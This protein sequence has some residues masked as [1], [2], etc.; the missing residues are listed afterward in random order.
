M[1]AG[2]IAVNFKKFRKARSFKMKL[3]ITGAAGLLGADIV[4]EAE[5]KN[6]ETVKVRLNDDGSGN[7]IAADIT[8]DAGIDL[9]DS[10]EWDTMIH[11]AAWRNPDQCEK[12][13]ESTY[14]I[15]VEA[16]GKLAELAAKRQAKMIYIST[17]Y[18]FAGTNPPYAEDDPTGPV[19]YYGETKLLGEQKVLAMVPGSASLRIPFL[20]G[21]RNG[22]ENS[23]MLKN[24]LDSIRSDKPWAM[25]DKAARY[26]TY[27]G[28]VAKALML[29]LEKDASGVYHFTGQDKTTKYGIVELISKITGGNMDNVY[30][31]TE[32]PA[33]EAV[34]PENS[35]LSMER[36]LKLG[37]ELPLPFEK[38]LE[39]IFSG[40]R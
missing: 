35:H 13:R 5:R 20:Y 30:R 17:D 19:N 32:P 34:R 15:N 22:I 10:L 29:M 1:L 16:T 28:D 14:K 18:V 26:P 8:T 38:R 2:N 6:I 37:G 39:I 27:T 11:T 9:L 21:I 4:Y 31:M 40:L 25:E 33:T 7:F 36:F 24:A 3:L 12:E 23:P